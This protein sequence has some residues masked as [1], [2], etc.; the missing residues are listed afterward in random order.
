MT[1]DFKSKQTQLIGG[2]L[3]VVI[4]L[5]LA[6]LMSGGGSKETVQSS[7]DSSSE[8]QVESSTVS[9]PHQIST[10]EETAQP[11]IMAEEDLKPLPLSDEELKTA[12][13]ERSLGDAK[14]PVT[15]TEYSSLTC[16]HCGAFHK[17]VFGKL[18]ADLI[19]SGKARLVISDFPLNGPALEAT[20]VARCLPQDKF[21][22]YV[23]LLFET[24]E[25]WA[26]SPD[27]K[28]YLKQNA[29]LAGLSAQK[30]ED[31]INSQALRNGL[32]SMIQQAQ[33]AHEINATPTF[34]LNGKTKLQG[35]QKAED[36]EKAVAEAAKAK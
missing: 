25:Q 1:I 10:S 4:V 12:L 30:F 28:K 16:S 14:A 21:F 11:D 6:F 36:F 19:D 5:A 33:K 20:M 7:P 8:A 22:D 31:C 2:G 29:Q 17:N 34:I 9:T 23:Q 3:L 13:S 26:Y 32:M 24:Q 15:I 27:Y 35:E 18:K